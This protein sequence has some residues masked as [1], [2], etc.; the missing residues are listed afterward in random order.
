TVALERTFG[1]VLGEPV[2]F[3]FFGSPVRH[4]EVGAKTKLNTVQELAPIETTLPGEPGTVVEVTLQVRATEVGTLDVAAVP[5]DPEAA[6]V[7]RWDLS[8]NVRGDA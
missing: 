2:S 7:P 8:F 4:D 5:L 6:G 3:R 1:I